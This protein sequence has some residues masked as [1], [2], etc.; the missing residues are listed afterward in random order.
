MCLRSECCPV[1]I[2]KDETVLQEGVLF[3]IR[4]K[5]KPQTFALIMRLGMC[6]ME[7]SPNFILKVAF[8]P[9]SCVCPPN[10]LCSLIWMFACLVL[11]WYVFN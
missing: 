10:S 6:N 5:I 3:L 8:C 4:S 9:N 1:M 2:V 7:F 11:T